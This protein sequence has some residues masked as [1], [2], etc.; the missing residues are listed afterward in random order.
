[1]NPSVKAILARCNQNRNTAIDYC[2]D[3][4]IQY[5]RLADEYQKYRRVF[6]DMPEK[7]MAANA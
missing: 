2:T 1:M 3:M 4:M 5:P 6:I 7:V